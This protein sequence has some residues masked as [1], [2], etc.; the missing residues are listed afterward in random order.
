MSEMNMFKVAVKEKF[1]FP[2]RGMVSVED[3]FDLSIQQLDSVFKSLNSQVK[4]SNEESL[5]ETKTKQD[6]ELDI[7]IA[8]V[9]EIFAEKVE[10]RN[11]ALQER[12][13][14]E[15][16]QKILSILNKKQDQALEDASEEELKEMLSNL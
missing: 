16:K 6:S 1:R 11:A 7:K 2:F 12:E 9:K 10:E 5:L 14:A 4:Q 8:I 15:K 13:N 3:L